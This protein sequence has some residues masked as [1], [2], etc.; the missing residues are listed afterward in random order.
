MGSRGGLDLVGIHVEAR[1]EHHV[2]LA[3]FDK[4]IAALVD[5]TDV[6]CAEPAAR[7]HDLR[8]L[9]RVVPVP[10]GN[11]WATQADLPD[12]ADPELLARIVPDGDVGRGNGKADRP[13]EVLGRRIDAGG[14]RGF[15]ESP[16]LRQDFPR[17]FLPALR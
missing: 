15:G 16:R 3:I 12:L 14:G 11:L 4:H 10:T 7:H 6:T 9:L 13:V 8:G 17:N 5:P 1:Y 2:L